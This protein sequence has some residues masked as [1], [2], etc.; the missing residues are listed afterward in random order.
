M[1]DWKMTSYV[2]I[3][4]LDELRKVFES[5]AE[6][7]QSRFQVEYCRSRFGY[8][9]VASILEGGKH[10]IGCPECGVFYVTNSGDV[11]TEPAPMGPRCAHGGPFY[12]WQRAREEWNPHRRKEVQ[13]ERAVVALEKIAAAA[14][15][16]IE[17]NP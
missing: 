15:H 11:T 7:D 16:Y 14:E 12:V 9:E 17:T 3:E 2:S 5:C 6:E 4:S 8:K 10:Q 13:F 1:I